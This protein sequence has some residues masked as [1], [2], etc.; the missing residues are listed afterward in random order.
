MKKT[1]S[2]VTNAKVNKEPI[3]TP[4]SVIIN[5]IFDTKFQFKKKIS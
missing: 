2:F 4:N 1:K 5:Y 3:M